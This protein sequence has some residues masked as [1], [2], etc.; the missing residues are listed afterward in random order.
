MAIHILSAQMP[1]IWHHQ[2]L[3]MG[4]HWGWWLLWIATVAVV[5]WA[6]VRMAADRRAARRE[7]ERIMAMENVLRERHHRGDIDD[8][9]F[10]RELTALARAQPRRGRG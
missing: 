8:E 2:G 5:V 10:A 3:F 4:M 6:F 1:Q 9:E 7:A